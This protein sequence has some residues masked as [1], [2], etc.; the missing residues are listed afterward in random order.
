MTDPLVSV[1]IAAYNADQFVA[2]T[3]ESALAQ[4]Y[5]NLEVCAVDDGSTDKTASGTHTKSYCVEMRSHRSQSM[6]IGS[7]SSNTP[8]W[9]KHS[10]L[11]RVDGK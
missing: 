5:R 7:D 6:P 11:T 10:R 2:S 9:A 8:Q 4:T 1:V 3:I